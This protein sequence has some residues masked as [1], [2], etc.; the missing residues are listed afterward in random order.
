MIG[1]Y[2]GVDEAAGHAGAAASSNAR[3]EELSQ[4]LDEPEDDDAR[5]SSRTSNVGPLPALDRLIGG[6]DARVGARRAGSSSRA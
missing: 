3:L 6:T 4:P 5:T 2:F 1:A